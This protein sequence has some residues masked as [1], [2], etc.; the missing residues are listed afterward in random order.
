M[1]FIDS[2]AAVYKAGTT[3]VYTV[4]WLGKSGRNLKNAF[5]FMGQ[6][7]SGCLEK[8]RGLAGKGW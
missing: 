4:G 1:F 3:K 5:S 8:T 2:M 6:S 7:L